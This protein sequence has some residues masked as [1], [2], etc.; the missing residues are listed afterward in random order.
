MLEDSLSALPSL[1]GELPLGAT[2]K[3]QELYVS[4][5]ALPETQLLKDSLLEQLKLQ[6][7]NKNL[8]SYAEKKNVVKKKKM[9]RD[10]QDIWKKLKERQKELKKSN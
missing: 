10:E 5:W 1:S 9:Q 2:L 3:L 6:E 4:W 7:K 8:F